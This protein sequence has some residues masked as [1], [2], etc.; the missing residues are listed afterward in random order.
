MPEVEITELIEI[1]PDRVDAV[2]S[3]ANGTE[4][5]IL[6]SIDG[7]EMPTDDE[8]ALAEIAK[9]DDMTCNACGGSGDNCGKCRGTGIMP[10]V[11]MSEKELAEIAK[12]HS[13]AS[14]QPVPAANDCPT[15]KG[16][17]LV[18]PVHGDE[19]ECPDCDGT[20]KDNKL[21]PADKLNRVDAEGHKIH[22]GDAAGRE[23]VD[24]ALEGELCEDGECDICVE[25]AKLSTK[26]R[27]SLPDSAFALP[28]RRYP[29]HDESHARN[30]L[31]RVAQNGTPEEKAKVEAAVKRR[32]PDID[33]DG[34]DASKSDGSMYLA[35][36]AAMVSTGSS[37][38]ADDSMVPGSPG[39][40]EWEAVDAQTAKDAALSLM[41]AAELIREFAQRESTEVAV[42]EGNDVFDTFVAED[43]LCGVTHALGIMAQ[44]AFHEALEAAKS[45]TDQDEIEKA[46][47]RLSTKSVTALAAARD[48]ISEL[49]GDDDPAKNDKNDQP[50]GKSA[51]EKFVESANKSE[52]NI[53]DMQEDDLQKLVATMVAQAV[54]AA[55]SVEEEAEKPG[56]EEVTETA[57]KTADT[58]AVE[59]AV[60]EVVE[61]AE[62]IEP[63]AVK[64][65][66]EPVLKAELTPEEIEANEATEKLR[67]ELAD[68]EARQK[69]VAANAALSAKIEEH[70]ARVVEQNEVLKSTVEDLK[71]EL[72]SVKKM[73]APSDI[74]RTAPA[75]A[76]SV[77]KARD[78]IEFRITMLENEARITP[79][80][81]VRAGNREIIK[82]LRAQLT[83]DKN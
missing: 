26:T 3:P 40:P 16:T 28:G 31:A 69:E 20:G 24:K 81:A 22:V 6:K 14:G 73:A 39:S 18:G 1:E 7:S 50:S 57:E 79:D 71:T 8:D 13:A 83:A 76:Q 2:G 56:D 53:L 12:V 60:V 77:A 36:P 15:C 38:D 27:N 48:H 70:L 45:L 74:V 10:K 49:L 66:E 43:A 34:D 29:I 33:V 82:E 11:G 64:A 59:E 46:G 44:L 4:W 37:D 65:V 62:V 54:V 51:A 78:E 63:E 58:P 17:G 55:K 23:A 47:K 42:G 68:A 80:P 52:G 21:P 41:A 9:A 25:K 72:E 5:L 67:K 19:T 35:S 32:Y 61:D 30:A 75:E